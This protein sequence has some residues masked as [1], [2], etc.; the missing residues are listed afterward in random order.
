MFGAE[1]ENGFPTQPTVLLANLFGKP[2]PS[3][4]HPGC[5]VE[6]GIQNAINDVQTDLA[7]NAHGIPPALTRAAIGV[8]VT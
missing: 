5:S 2:L 7:R 8:S 1:I 6:K 4:V 3:C